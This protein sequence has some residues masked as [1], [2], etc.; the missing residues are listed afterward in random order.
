MNS[1]PMCDPLPLKEI[2]VHMYK[3][4]QQLYLESIENKFT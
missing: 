2:H 1:F 4:R 3:K